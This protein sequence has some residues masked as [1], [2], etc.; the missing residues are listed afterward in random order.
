AF[1]NRIDV[2]VAGAAARVDLHAA[3]LAYCEARGARQLVA[4]PDA[5]REN[6]EVR[7]EMGPV[8]VDQPVPALRAIH[9]FLR[10]LL[11]V[12]LRA[13]RTTLRCA[14]IARTAS[15]RRSVTLLS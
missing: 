6:D 9:D 7:L 13:E 2:G 10:A 12:N 5:R 11:Q 8:G 15:F 4:R 14:S 1:A 3:A